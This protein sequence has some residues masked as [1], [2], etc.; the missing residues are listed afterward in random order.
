MPTR[1]LIGRLTVEIALPGA[2][3]AL[4]RLQEIGG[5]ARSDGLWRDLSRALDQ[6]VPPDEVVTIPRLELT[7][8]VNSEAAFQ[9]QLRRALTRAVGQ[10]LQRRDSAAGRRSLGQYTEALVW[11]FLATGALPWTAPQDQGPAVAN[12]LNNLPDVEN[13]AFV[14]RLRAA[15]AA[16]PVPWQRLV[17]AIGLEKARRLVLRYGSFA[18][19]QAAELL[20]IATAAEQQSSLAAIRFWQN[21][22]INTELHNSEIAAF[23]GAVRQAAQAAGATAEARPPVHATQE[24]DRAAAGPTAA[25]EPVAGAY[26]VQNAGLVLL[27]QFLPA[28]FRQTDLLAG[29]DFRD[30]E[31]RCQAIH[32]LQFLATGET[33]AYEYD[34]LLNKLL[35]AHPLGRPVPRWVPLTDADLGQADELLRAAIGHWRVLRNTSVAGLRETFLRRPGKLAPAEGGGW[36]LQVERRTVDILLDRLPMGWGYSV[37]SLP[38]RPDL[39]FVEW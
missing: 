33:E 36:R 14:E 26:F 30:E 17:Y 15:S 24:A 29:D 23:R 28:Q 18:P 37:V 27:N 5:W 16:S 6:L 34:L 32:L 25:D 35:C 21:I 10:L 4:A 7:V 2:D 31:A 3:G 19:P 8:E 1:H 38:W 20:Q 11:H 12:F 22:F 13:E 39:I 9:S